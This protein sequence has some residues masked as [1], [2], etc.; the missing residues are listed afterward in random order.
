MTKYVYVW[1]ATILKCIYPLVY[2]SYRDVQQASSQDT[3]KWKKTLTPP[4]ARAWEF[5][6]FVIYGRCAWLVDLR[7]IFPAD[8]QLSGKTLKRFNPKRFPLDKPIPNEIT[9]NYTYPAFWRRQ[10]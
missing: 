1:Y 4:L 5:V 3:D 2:R 9:H 6:H 8:H 7:G 10:A